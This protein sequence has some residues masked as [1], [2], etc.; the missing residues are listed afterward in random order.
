MQAVELK[1]TIQGEPALMMVCGA[2]AQR[3]KALKAQVRKS[4]VRRVNDKELKARAKASGDRPLVVLFGTYAS[5]C[6][7]CAGFM[8][9]FVSVASE[10]CSRADFVT[11]DAMENPSACGKFSVKTLPTVLVWR[12]WES[13]RVEGRNDAAVRNMLRLTLGPVNES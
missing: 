10:F 8:P 9:E 12:G 4:V 1:V 13:A 6:S 11:I 7:C 3:F 5:S 2:C